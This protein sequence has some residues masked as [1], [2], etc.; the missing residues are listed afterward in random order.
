MLF[1]T[2]FEVVEIREDGVRIT[3]FFSGRKAAV[4]KDINDIKKTVKNYTMVGKN[5]MIVWT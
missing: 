2:K 4:K 5:G 3:H 1:R